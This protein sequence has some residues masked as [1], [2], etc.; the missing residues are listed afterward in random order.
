MFTRVCLKALAFIITTKLEHASQHLTTQKK[1]CK[2]VTSS[3][4]NFTRKQN[5]TEMNKKNRERKNK[6]VIKVVAHKKNGI[7][8]KSVRSRAKN[9]KSTFPT[10]QLSDL[11]IR[12]VIFGNGFSI[13]A[14]RLSMCQPQLGKCRANIWHNNVFK[15]MEFDFKCNSKRDKWI[16]GATMYLR[17]VS[18]MAKMQ[19]RDT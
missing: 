2:H 17:N 14:E 19:I 10:T 18:R 3:R 1:I 9:A 4:D 7:L 15:I 6:Y 5:T 13:S 8:I 16:G 12:K 11:T